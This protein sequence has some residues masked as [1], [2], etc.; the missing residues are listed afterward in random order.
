MLAP[1]LVFLLLSSAVPALAA[2]GQGKISGR[3][4]EIR[5]DGKLVIEE[6]GPWNGPG[7]G[8]LRR[9]VD[10]TPGTSIRVVRPTGKWTGSDTTPGYA[11]EPSDFRALAP[12]DFVT[13]TT[14][15]TSTAAAIDVMRMDGDAAGA[16]SP[17]MDSIGSK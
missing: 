1:A 12:G 9:T 13:V 11:V 16:A 15:G 8:L 2:E 14:G 4:V 17:R 10:L 6:Q 3:L 5:P 7:T